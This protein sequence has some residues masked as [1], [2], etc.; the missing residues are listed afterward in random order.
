[1]FK[2]LLLCLFISLSFMA[3]AQESMLPDVSYAYLDKLIATAKEN[4]PKVKAMERRVKIAQ[5]NVSKAKM[6]WFDI[7]SFTYLYSP[8]NST[9]L[10]NPSLLNGYQFGLFFSLGS[11]FQKP[12]LVR[13]AKQDFE[14]AKLDKQEYNLNI[15][16]EVKSR[17]FTYIGQKTL[18]RMQSRA[19]LDAESVMKEMKYKFEKGE[20]GLDNY[21]TSLI[22]LSQIQQRVIEAESAVLIAKS[23]LEEIVGKKLEEIN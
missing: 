14:I 22:A 17:Y 8:N 1:M 2:Y 11:L 15:E 3:K 5:N 16:A 7:V 21:N 9:T 10:T 6:S 13:N 23:K 18:V 4:Y 20:A 19:A 12:S